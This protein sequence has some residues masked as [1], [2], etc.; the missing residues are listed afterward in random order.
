MA[1]DRRQFYTSDNVRLELLP[2]P[3][4]EKRRVE[5][6]FYLEHFDT[7]VASEPFSAELGEAALSLAKR[8][9]LS[10]GD[11]LNLAAAVRQGVE[12]FITSELPGRP[13]F[14]VA[15]LSVISLRAIRF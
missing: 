4:F 15:E 12:E 2:K 9:G 7:S 3:T 10:A 13:L 6:E 8:Y 11:S 5:V 14:R 1:D